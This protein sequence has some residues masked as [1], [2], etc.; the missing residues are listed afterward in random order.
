MTIR[1]S[2]FLSGAAAILLLGACI[3]SAGTAADACGGELSARVPAAPVAGRGETGLRLLKQ[4][5]A[6]LYVPSGYRPGR[7]M[8]LL[9]MLHG[10]GGDARHSMLLA[11]DHAERLGFLV[12]APKSRAA[13]W[14]VVS[15]RRY[16]PDVSALD[17]ALREVFEAYSVDPARVAVAGFSDGA[18]YALALGRAN[19][20]LFSHVF[21]FAPGFLAPARKQGKPRIFISHGKSDRV[22]PIDDTGRR[23]VHDLTEA[24][25]RVTYE[26]FPGGHEVPR[27]L[28]QRFFERL[29]AA[30]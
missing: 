13:T 9:V 19:G 8:P 25:Y 5:G 30:P 28:A 21:A 3:P 22:L 18:T 4:Q 14:D 1:P 10:A 23:V 11:G 15:G 6:L 24:G 7:A 16:G 2:R 17:S 20:K 27:R 12:I 29:V 26:E